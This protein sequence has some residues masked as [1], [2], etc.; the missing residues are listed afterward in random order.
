MNE[1]S[2]SKSNAGYNDTDSIIALKEE[3]DS[4]RAKMRDCGNDEAALDFFKTELVL[5]EFED[6]LVMQFNQARD[7]IIARSGSVFHP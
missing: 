3:V 5:N 4:Q 2:F 7:S 6:A 1:L